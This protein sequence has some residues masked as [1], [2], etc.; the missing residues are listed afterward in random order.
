MHFA[1]RPLIN[2][3]RIIATLWV[4]KDITDLRQMQVELM[5]KEYLLSEAQQLAHLG[6]WE[7]NVADNRMVWS[8][9]MYRIYGCRPDEKITLARFK[10]LIDEADRVRVKRLFKKA[11][12][13]RKGFSFY[14]Q[15]MVNGKDKVIFVKGYIGQTPD[16]TINR[17]YGIAQDVTER[18]EKEKLLEKQNREL[19][20]VNQELDRFIYSISH[21]LRS[22]IASMM[23][24]CNYARKKPIRR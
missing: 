3:G 23:G 5:R 1:V 7:W 20:K 18:I 6:N 8:D 2:N 24:L 15:T 19:E 12:S 21:D 16:G 22:P 14:H 13:S 17:V 10:Q 4:G 11:L 9:E